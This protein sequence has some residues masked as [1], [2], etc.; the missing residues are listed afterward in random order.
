MFFSW[1][2][3]GAAIAH[4]QRSKVLKRSTVGVSTT[5]YLLPSVAVHTA[6]QHCVHAVLYAPIHWFLI[7]P[8]Y[9]LYRA[10]QRLYDVEVR[11]GDASYQRQ[12]PKIAAQSSSRDRYAKVAAFSSAFWPH[13]DVT[14]PAARAAC[15]LAYGLS[16]CHGWTLSGHCWSSD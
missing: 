10:K 12:H 11:S 9:R 6:D 1:V 5:D 4:S 3:T 13:A 16:L 15:H 14:Q 7:Q 2:K 8:R